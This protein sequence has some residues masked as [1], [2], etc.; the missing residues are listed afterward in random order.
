LNN[1]IEK[2]DLHNERTNKLRNARLR[3][4]GENKKIEE[5]IISKTNTAVTYE[6]RT[7]EPQI[8]VTR[9]K[10]NHPEPEKTS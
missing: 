5:R 9:N 4:K 1:I 7:T 6:I 10:N 2:R 3:I 8:Q